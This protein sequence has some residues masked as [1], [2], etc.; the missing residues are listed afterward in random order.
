MAQRTTTDY[1]VGN[2]YRLLKKIG[3]GGMGSVFQ[4]EDRLSVSEQVIALKR[5]KMRAVSA[6]SETD[7]REAFAREFQILAGLRHPHVISVLDFGY[8]SD[9]RPYFTMPLLKA[10]QTILEAAGALPL[11]DKVRLDIETLQ[12][13]IYLQRHGILHRDLKPN[14]I[15]VEPNGRLRVLDF[16]IATESITVN[17]PMNVSGTLEYIAPEVL[18]GESASLS[19]D[20]YALGVIAY[21]MFA[22]KHPF[23]TESIAQLVHKVLNE[24]PDADALAGPPDVRRVV[25]HLLEK[26]PEARYPTAYD[27]MLAFS[28]AIGVAPSETPILRESVLQSPKFV[29]RVPEL[30]LFEEAL[31]D[32]LNGKGSAW[33]IG[34]ESGV[35]KT[36]LLDEIRIRALVK[37][38]LVVRWQ[39][40]EET[41]GIH[42]LWREVLRRLVL[43]IPIHD[44]EARLLKAFVPDLERLLG[45]TVPESSGLPDNAQLAALLIALIER[46]RQPIVLIIDDVHWSSDSLLPLRQLTK[47]AARLPLTVIAA[48][49]SDDD[50]YFYG[51]LPE[52]QLIKLARF[53]ADEVCAL[54]ASVIGNDERF[55]QINNF[56]I[57]H[58]EGNAFYVI[59]SLRTLAQTA[60]SLEHICR[61]GL[62]TQ[63][64]SEGMLLVAKR[65][66]ARLKEKYQTLVQLAAVIGREIDF[67][68]LEHIGG[69]A[70]Y[71]DWL[72]K[73]VDVALVRIQD[74]KWY[75][76]HDK[77]REGVLHSLSAEDRQRWHRA[78]AE[79]IEA[80]YPNQPDYD[81]ALALH[82]READDLSR[83]IAYLCAYA[84]RAIESGNAA[85][86]RVQ[87]EITL[88]RASQAASCDARLALLH[89]L[90]GQCYKQSANSVQAEQHFLEAYSLALTL[91]NSA[92]QAEALYHIGEVKRIQSNFRA[93]QETLQNALQLYQQLGDASG[94]AK[95]L[96]TLGY[97]YRL[98]AALDLAE[99]HYQAALQIAQHSRDLAALAD[100]QLGL[101]D[102]AY[103]RKDFPT[104]EKYTRLA[105]EYL[106][107]TT[108]ERLLSYCLSR[109]SLILLEKKHYEEA[110]VMA[111]QS[112]AISQRLGDAQAMLTTIGNTGYVLAQQERYTECRPYFEHSITLAQEM[113]NL[114]SLANRLAALAQVDVHL[115]D[116]EA[117]RRSLYEWLQIAFGIDNMRGL[118]HGFYA[119]CDLAL[120]ENNAAQAA[121]WLGVIEANAM[122][123]HLDPNELARLR[124]LCVAALGESATAEA[125]AYGKMLALNTLAQDLLSDVEGIFTRLITHKKA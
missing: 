31:A 73:C 14:N 77:I 3:E 20:L 64:L 56:L 41:G 8:D 27:A 86:V 122:P 12:A 101:C 9:L 26:T 121:E 112:I 39:C 98:Q 2:R 81:L 97:T 117:V 57:E 7:Q 43:F 28:A 37:G 18:R 65:R 24:V 72:I 125:V 50:Q 90:L 5:V 70:N 52:M 119:L 108:H 54:T 61:A 110:L 23:Q 109:L 17:D 74:D 116:W 120:H 33:L 111:E 62:P 124:A 95:T 42:I 35:G 113:N 11:Q 49:R 75:F 78:V 13:H 59:E 103:Y 68:L 123:D 66:L 104:A 79:G 34:G 58:T 40:A 6:Q 63:I 89:I 105:L 19:A 67:N 82:W 44:H 25:L 107:T 84:P 38:A 15:L 4:A 80:L 22:G 1:L 48:Y 36:R 99:Q 106:N 96:N 91:G 29:G 16:G 47:A 46:T 55:A 100:A 88:Q 76:T 30:K 69:E 21:R 118:L 83:E 92:A 32:T 10:S 60:G 45:R 51:K 115:G 94:T 85:A 93:A 53:S 87:L 102:V 71:D 114:N